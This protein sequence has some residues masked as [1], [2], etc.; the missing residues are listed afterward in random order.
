MTCR[1][2]GLFLKEKFP[3]KVQKISINA[4]FTCPNRDGSKGRGGCTYCNNRTFSPQYAAGGKS[5]TRQ[6]EEGIRFF[7][8]KYPAMKYLA[9]F[10][11]YTN[12]YGDIGRLLALY[13]EALAFPEVV[14]LIISTRP[15]CVPDALLDELGK[16]AENRFLL[17]EYGIESTCDSTLKLINRCHTY[18]D[19]IEAVKR[20][21]SRGIYC[22]AH[23]ILGLPGEDRETLL[24]HADR[25]SELPL[26]TLKLHQ[27]QIIKGSAM[28]VQYRENPE[29]FHLFT[30][31]EYIDLCID[32]VKRLNPE[33][34][35]ERLTSQ[36]PAELLAVPG[37]GL[38]NHEF[39]AK[40]KAKLATVA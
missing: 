15:D 13:R 33:F 16:I 10:Q 31:D 25:I 26:T 39:T 18:E 32:F 40:W 24:R 23:L 19:S 28:E 21:H 37:W 11:S 22:G 20:T 17:M 8:R 3:F 29:M 5:V 4:G 6:L 9:Y 34:Y 2:F 38:K 1:D 7:S 36:S 12:T 35:I 14:G 27:L 30:V